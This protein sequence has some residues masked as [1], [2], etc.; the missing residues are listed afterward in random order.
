MK[1]Q[2]TI[3]STLILLLTEA[4]NKTENSNLLFL[5]KNTFQFGFQTNLGLGIGL[6]REPGSVLNLNPKVHYFIFDRLSVGIGYMATQNRVMFP[7]E[8]TRPFRHNMEIE[9]KY[10]LVSKKSYFLYSQIGYFAGQFTPL[11]KYP[12]SVNDNQLNS[13][14]K[15]GIGFGYRF[16]NN[17]NLCFNMELNKYPHLRTPGRSLFQYMPNVSVGFS[18]S[19]PALGKKKRKNYSGTN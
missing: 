4:Q 9:L 13:M 3:V 11:Q 2:L 6:N 5:K 17:P 1:I 12:A 14:L 7:G 18:Y 15:L 19:L 8:K 10:Y 16:K